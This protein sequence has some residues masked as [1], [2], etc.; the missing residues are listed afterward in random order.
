MLKRKIDSYLSD[1]FLGDRKALLVSGARQTGK[2]YSIRR[3]GREHFEHFV[4][5]NLVEQP[6]A[7][8]IFSRARSARDILIHLSAFVA[9]PLVPGRTLIFIDEVQE[10]PEIV[11]AIKFLVDEGSYRYI[12]S[13]SLLGVMLRDIR[14]LPVGY[15]ATK[16]MFPLDFEEFLWGVGIGPEAIA[17]VREAWEARRPVDEVLHRRLLDI[18]RLYLVVGGMPAV[19]QR[20]LDTENIRQVVREQ[21]AIV[22]LYKRNI[23][24]Y[25]PDRKLYIHDS[26]MLIPSELDAKNKRFILKHLHEEL[27]FSRY[28]NSFL[29]LRDTGVALPTYNVHEP[30]SP[31]RISRSRNLFKLF[32]GDIGLLLSAYADARMQLR[33]LNGDEMLNHGAFFENVVAQELVAHGHALYYFHSKKQGELDFVVEHGGSVLPIEVKSGKDYARHR[34]LSGVLG[35]RSYDI[36][37]GLV[38]CMENLRV[39]G[40]VLYAPIYMTMCLTQGHHDALDVQLDLRGMLG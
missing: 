31:L 36:P 18:F 6:D 30:R 38:L 2:T 16:Q 19:V 32:M 4:E 15:M 23:G 9:R 25:D 12:L 26:F 20:F 29:W 10:C 33:V 35:D 21:E 1:A 40:R 11:T 17:S 24:K 34:A 27:R 39:E 28:E 5:L 37:Y 13:G 22:E 3:F 8:P 7:R 14:S